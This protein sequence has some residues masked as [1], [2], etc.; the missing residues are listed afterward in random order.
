MDA[1]LCLRRWNTLHPMGARFEFQL[2]ED[3][4]TGH[5]TD[6]F[7]VPAVLTTIFADDLDGQRVTFGVTRVHA[8][9][10]AG[11]NGRFVAAGAGA[12]FQEDVLVV[13][14]VFRDQQLA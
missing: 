4:P 10:V 5:A 11:E 9:Q 2:R 1:P 3:T 7:A 6:D 8:K 12:D 14:R 13:P